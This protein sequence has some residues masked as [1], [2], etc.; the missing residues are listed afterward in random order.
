[1]AWSLKTTFIIITLSIATVTR[2]ENKVRK[3]ENLCAIR[4]LPPFVTFNRSLLHQKYLVA[5]KCKN[6]KI[7]PW[8]VDFNL[9]ISQEH[10]CKLIV[11]SNPTLVTNITNVKDKEVKLEVGSSLPLGIHTIHAKNVN[12]KLILLDPDGY[13]IHAKYDNVTNF[14]TTKYLDG[15]QI[16]KPYHPNSTTKTKEDNNIKVTS[17]FDKLVASKIPV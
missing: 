1:M 15:H 2:G 8:C 5:H 7:S 6:K 4:V 12:L 14:K 17:K 11:D 10:P 13:R 3:E 9:G 16:Q